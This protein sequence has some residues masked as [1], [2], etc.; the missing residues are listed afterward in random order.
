[1]VN[2]LFRAIPVGL[3]SQG[4]IPLSKAQLEELIV[5][6]VYWAIERGYGYEQ[7]ANVCEEEECREGANPSKVS[8]IAKKRG[9]Q[10]LGSLGS[11][12]HFLE[13]QKVDQI[14]DEKVAQAFGIEQ[15]GQIT[16]LIRCGSR[17]FGHQIC[18]D[19]LRISENA[20][21]KY[22]LSLPDNELA[23]VPNNSKEGEDYRAAMN[24]ALNFAWTNRQMI[25]H[26]VRMAFRKVFSLTDQ[27]V[28]NMKLVY[29][30]AHNIAKVERHR[31]D[32][33]G[34]REL[35]VHR[36]GATRAFPKGT[37]ELPK[38]YRELGQPVMLPGSMGTA[39]WLLLGNRNSM[40]LSFGSTA[41]GAGRIM[42]RSAAKRAYSLEKV[43]DIL[44]EQSLRQKPHTR[45]KSRRGPPGI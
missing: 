31:I 13:V 4:A 33:E 3:G 27:E 26:W 11:G 18:T 37:N 6:G 16:I 35:I 42:S 7:D 8:D 15:Q 21:A 28:E 10:Q 2:E 43:K 22:H 17:G 40:N 24:S 14:Y 5:Q 38:V 32:G 29:D 34:M 44:R 39:S 30:V 23:C 36:K 19:Y 41:H 45:R 9:L 1:L 12:N 20:L 25:T